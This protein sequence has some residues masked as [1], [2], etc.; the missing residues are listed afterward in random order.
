MGKILGLSCMLGG[1]VSLG[2][3]EM[4]QTV[5]AR[6]MWSQI[7]HQLTGSVGAGFRKGTMAFA[8]LDARHFSF[9][10]Y[11]TGAFQKASQMLELRK[12][13]SE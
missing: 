10:L 3:S 6:L 5:L 13:T 7:W 9:S 4:G 12:N 1:V 8:C 11:T 2:I